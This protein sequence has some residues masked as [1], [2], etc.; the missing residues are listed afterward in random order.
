VNVTI[1]HLFYWFWE[2][3]EVS[4]FYAF[5][6]N[7]EILPKDFAKSVGFLINHIKPTHSTENWRPLPNRMLGWGWPTNLTLYCL[8]SYW[9]YFVL[10][11]SWHLLCL[12]YVGVSYKVCKL[13]LSPL[14]SCRATLLSTSLWT[15]MFQQSSPVPG[16]HIQPLHIRNIS[17]GSHSL[18]ISSFHHIRKLFSYSFLFIHFSY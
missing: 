8:M 6:Q 14:P 5:R 10:F 7:S 12:N 2:N 13:T 18:R 4:A 9:P 3:E 16:P 17:A 15:T 11:H 1:S